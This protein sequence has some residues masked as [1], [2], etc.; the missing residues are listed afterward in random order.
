MKKFIYLLLTIIAISAC[1][2]GDDIG[3]NNS[4]GNNGTPKPTEI[5]LNATSSDFTTS[6]GSSEI[7]FTSSAAWTAEVINS[8]A[9]SWCSV[10][11]KSGAAGEAKIT[12]TTTAN[13][14]PDDRSASIV[15]KAGTV[16]KSITVSQKQK[17]ALTV[18]ASKFEV[19]AMGGE[20]SIEVK[21]N[22]DF[23][24]T[25]EESAKDWIEYKGTRAL[26]TSNLVFEVKENELEEKREAKI[27]I[28]SGEFREVITIYQEG[29]KP[30]ITLTQRKYTVPSAGQTIAVLVKSNVDVSVEMPEDAYWI[31]EN[32]TRATSTNT[33]YF[34]INQ[35]DSYEN[36]TAEIKFTNKENK[37]SETIT[38]T[39]AQKDA[40]VIAENSYAVKSRGGEINI[41]IGHNVD[42]NIKIDGDW[43]TQ[44]QT[45]AL[46]TSN[47]T[48]VVAENTTDKAREGSITFT[49]KNGA[50]SQKIIVKQGV[51]TYNIT[52]TTDDGKIVTP[53]K[54]AY[55]GANIVSNIYE[56]G[57]GVITFDGKITSIVREAFFNCQSLTSVTI[58]DSVTT[59]ENAAFALCCFLTS[60]TIPDS[61]TTIENAAFSDCYYLTSITI[62]DSVTSIG[63]SAFRGCPL[64]SVYCKPTT[65]PSL[66]SYAFDYNA[67]DR[68][69]YVPTASV[70]T[71][72]AA[73]EWKKYAD[74]I[75]TD[76]DNDDIIPSYQIWY[77]S[78]NSKIVRPYDDA[79]DANIN[80]NVYENG[81]GIITFYGKITS[82]GDWAFGNF[83][84]LTS[85]TIPD[86]VTSI[87]H[88]A[89]SGCSSLTSITI[90]DSVTSIERDTFYGCSSITN[91]TLPDNVTSIGEAAFCNCIS[92]TSLTIPE[93]V[94]SIGNGAFAGCS[95]I[96]DLTIPESVTSIG[97]SAFYDCSSITSI[98]IPESVKSIGRHAFSHCGGELTVNCNIPDASDYDSSVFSYAYFSKVTIGDKVTKIGYLAFSGC[99][100]LTSVIIGNSVTEIGAQA[101]EKCESL[102]SITIPNSVTSIGSQAFRACNS[103]ISFYGKFASSDNRYLII[104]GVLTSFAPAGLTTYIIPNSVTSIGESAFEDCESLGSV[105]IPNSVTEIGKAAFYHCNH[106]TSVYCKSTT[107]PTLGSS[108]AFNSNGY[109]RKIYV[110]LASVNIYKTQWNSYRSAIVGFNFTE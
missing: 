58:P 99:A 51:L 61:V 110:P 44:K 6:G 30:S 22:I 36:R 86:S 38:I 96:T 63:K 67:A 32:A 24:Y 105:T 46:E 71:Y 53:N 87:G 27:T 73:D 82:I 49:S 9:D 34:D 25:I 1:S 66:G 72:R 2:K 11:P 59:I 40:I 85:I 74:F 76:T 64:K 52:Y 19:R 68:R 17:D 47:L 69:I 54:T 12:V 57:V 62:P 100:N 16:S 23:E 56:N 50:I 102:T 91:I 93:S 14:T 109:N 90:P 65:P 13:D 31:T 108:S 7:T 28:K 21:A 10:N 43:I 45:R 29:S 98:T 97:N 55:F 20:V 83:N 33:Y 35:N 8:R 75:F 41:E 88:E 77:T 37:L 78:K 26:E 48:F 81:K 60:V 101:F 39:Q 18:T 106:L 84:N 92:I 5:T 42:F 104:D 89:F 15:I 95:S 80:S 103:L 3:G 94:T 4:N 107:P 79:F 70:D